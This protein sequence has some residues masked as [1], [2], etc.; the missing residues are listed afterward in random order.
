MKLASDSHR[1]IIVLFTSVFVRD[2]WLSAK[3]VIRNFSAS[4]IF[5]NASETDKI[6]INERATKSE[7]ENFNLAKQF[8]KSDAYKFVW[9]KNGVTFLKKTESAPAV[10]IADKSDLDKLKNK[11]KQD[12]IATMAPTEQGATTTDQVAPPTNPTDSGA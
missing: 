12:R 7:R 10:R 8:A 11:L 3:K 2:S 4:K 9:M 6:F 5:H 1:P